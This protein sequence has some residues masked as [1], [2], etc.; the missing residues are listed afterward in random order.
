MLGKVALQFKQSTCLLDPILIPQL[1]SLEKV[2]FNGLNNFITN[3][4]NK[5]YQS[6]VRAH[7]IETLLMKVLNYLGHNLV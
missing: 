1:K 6:V 3:N 7:S 5:I 4:I 2:V